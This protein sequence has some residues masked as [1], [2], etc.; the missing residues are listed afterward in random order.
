MK[1]VISV[2]LALILV[3]SLSAAA[4]AD[5]E[6]IEEP[7]ESPEVQ[8]D[9][10][11][12][13]DKGIGIS[14]EYKVNHGTTPLTNFIVHFVPVSYTDG[15]GKV[16]SAT[17][18]DASAKY[19]INCDLD[20]DG[21][22]DYIPQFRDGFIL[23][24]K[25]LTETTTKKLTV[26]S[27][28]AWNVGVFNNYK[29]VGVYKYKAIP[30]VGVKAGVTY[31]TTPL[32]LSLT[33]LRDENSGKHYVAAVHYSTES[34]DKTESLHEVYDSGE[35][36]VTKQI[37]GNM[38][39]MNKKFDFTIT[40][41]V[42]TGKEWYPNLSVVYP[43]GDPDNP[44]IINKINDTKTSIKTTDTVRTF[45]I[46]TQLGAGESITIDNI[47]AGLIYSVSETEVEGYV[48]TISSGS[49]TGTITAGTTE[50][51]VEFTNTKNSAVDT[52]IT[53]DSVPY[54]V[55]LV[56]AAAGLAFFFVRKRQN[57]E[58]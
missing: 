41:E 27:T 45:T 5:D 20:G 43:D 9:L 10:S 38:A 24:F 35:L 1:R 2:L 3:L 11:N 55:A 30:G 14:L 49:E 53:M 13:L 34:G 51:A 4:F 8:Q 25:P 31:D 29:A 18:N 15:D 22:N 42:P 17:Y 47:P 57:S 32:Y 21:E 33:I 56:V 12:Y 26:D 7:E 48:K 46:T 54:I 44:T 23:Q 28:G 37:S 50:Y 40:L 52:G 6:V 39:D 19:T 58:N 36:T 16:Y